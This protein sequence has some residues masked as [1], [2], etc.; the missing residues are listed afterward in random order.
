M[1]DGAR[2]HTLADADRLYAAVADR[3][4]ALAES[5]VAARGRF[6]LALAGGNTPRRLYERLAARDDTDWNRWE[7]WFGDERCVAPEH[8]DSNYRMAR[9]TLLAHV[10]IPASQVHPMI[11]D[12][13][14]APERAAADYADALSAHLPQQAGWPILDAVLLGL[15]PDGHTASLFPGT[16]IL[17]VL[18]TP[19]AA[20]HVPRLS[21]WRISL[22]LPVLAHARHLLFVVEGAGKSDVLARLARGPAAGEPPLPVERVSGPRAEWYLDAA[23]RGSA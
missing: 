8:Q 16:P 15:G 23:A 3:V 17:D 13:A 20:V 21:A 1:K 6:H 2:C 12:P 9:E 4:I 10:P 7:I 11:A 18:D 14:I 22:T 5:A 19:V